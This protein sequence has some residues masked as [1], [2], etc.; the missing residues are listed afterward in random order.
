MSWFQAE[1]TGSFGNSTAKTWPFSSEAKNS[2]EWVGIRAARVLANSTMPP[3]LVTKLHSPLAGS[4][5][6][7][8]WHS[9]AICESPESRPNMEFIQRNKGA[10]GCLSLSLMRHLQ[11]SGNSAHEADDQI[12]LIEKVG[13]YCEPDKHVSPLGLMVLLLLYYLLRA[14]RGFEAASVWSISQRKWSNQVTSRMFGLFFLLAVDRLC[15]LN[16]LSLVQPCFCPA[17]AGCARTTLNG[18][19]YEEWMERCFL[20]AKI[21]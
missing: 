4:P 7:F 19:G 2:C 9:P 12:S 6:P 8:Q 20:N 17:T 3:L 18:S 21:H 16:K 5:W 1:G 11:M 15:L 14:G 10:A 13:I